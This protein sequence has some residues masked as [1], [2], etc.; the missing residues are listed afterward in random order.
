MCMKLNIKSIVCVIDS[1]IF[2]S[3]TSEPAGVILLERCTVE[4]DAKEELPYS[5]LLGKYSLIYILML[6]PYAMVANLANI[7]F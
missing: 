6:N 5:F 7:K 1:L 2:S 4:L 3:Q